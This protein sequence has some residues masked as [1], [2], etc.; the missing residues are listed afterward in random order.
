MRMHEITR[1]YFD[2]KWPQHTR[3][4]FTQMMLGVNTGDFNRILT[5]M[6]L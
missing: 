6:H 1:D 3:S 2:V 5:H 4:I